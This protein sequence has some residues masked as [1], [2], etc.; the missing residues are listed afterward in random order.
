M[1]YTQSIDHQ[2]NPET[3]S[4][5]QY[6]VWLAK[7]FV[8][9][10]WSRPYY[11]EASH[12]PMGTAFVFLL[13]F[14]VL[15]AIISTGSIALNLNQF[16]REIEEAYLSGEIPDIVIEDGIASVSGSGRHIILKRGWLPGR[17]PQ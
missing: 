12:K 17:T 15:Q 2:E 1:N 5:L 4:I 11:K 9:P 16:G 6:F 7:G 10:I 14:G 13:V 8:Y 3:T